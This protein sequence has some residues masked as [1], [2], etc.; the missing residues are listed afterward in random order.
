M[1]KFLNTGRFF[2][3]VPMLIYPVLHF[4]Y[5]AFVA[6]IVPPWIPWHL[7][8]T[9][10]TAITIFAAGV[11]IVIRRFAY[12][13]AVLLGIEILLFVLI[14]HGELLFHN[15]NDAWAESALFPKLM[16]DRFINAFK[17]FGLC[18]AVFVF[19]GTLPLVTKTSLQGVLFVAGRIILGLSIAAFGL[20]HFVYPQYAPGIPPMYADVT[21]II[22]GHLF[23]V[24]VTGAGLLATGLIIVAGKETAK[25]VGWLGVLLLVFD[26][27]VWAPRFGT[28]PGDLWGNWL[29]DLGVIGGVIILGQWLTKNRLQPETKHGLKREQAA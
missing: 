17:D 18:G 12:P 1:N 6:A 11:A 19:A 16:S 7:F 13:A 10:F 15:S 27:L 23:W 25:L 22:P 20:L 21:F 9:Y 2:L 26:V 4:I 3:A 8:W 28:H 5:P 14:I 24:Y 29:K